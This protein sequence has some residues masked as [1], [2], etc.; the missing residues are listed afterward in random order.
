MY[1]C[2]YVCMYL[3]MCMYVYI[4]MYVY[5]DGNVNMYVFNH[6][7]SSVNILYMMIAV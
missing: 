5:G 3:F 6:T 1:V 2:M 7:S 4:C